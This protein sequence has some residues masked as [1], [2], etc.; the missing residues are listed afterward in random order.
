MAI[1]IAELLSEPQLGLSLL[2]GWE[3]IDRTVAWSH[4]SDLPNVWEWVSPGVLLMTNGLSIPADPGLL[5]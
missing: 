2:A 1:N 3:G 4:T 5:G